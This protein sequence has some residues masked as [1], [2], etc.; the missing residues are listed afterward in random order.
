MPEP[1][2][3]VSGLR[4]IVGESLTEDVA[5][6]YALAFSSTLP[7][8]KFV[9]TN[10]ARTS[11]G[12][13]EQAIA[14]VLAQAGR[15]VFLGGPAATPTLGVLVR[16]EQAVGGIQISASHNPAQYN[17]MKLF[18]ADGRVLPAEAGATVLQRYHELAQQ[19]GK[20]AS[21]PVGKVARLD[22]PHA[23]H[24]QLIV[25]TV[26]AERIR[27]RKYRVLLDS[28]HGAGGPG[29]AR[30]LQE[31]G[32]Q[33]VEVGTTPD[34]AYEHPL[35]PTEENPQSVLQQARDSQCDVAFC[36]DPDADRLAV[37]DANGRYLGEELTLAMCVDHR[38]RQEVGPVVVNCSSSRVTEDIAQ[39]YGAPYF[40]SKV[41]EANVV[42]RMLAEDAVI[43]GEGNGGAID[44]RIV[45]VRDS[46]AG[47][48]LILEAMAS[49]ELSVAQLADELPQYA[50]V[51]SKVAMA[52]DAV[53]DSFAKLTGHFS[54]A[55]AD[56]LDGL[57]LDWPNR[58]LLIRASNTE[59]IVRMIA[60]AESRG[61][62]QSL[63]DQAAQVLE[64][65][66]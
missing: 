41:G 66:S 37:I 1:I 53:G 64:N 34:A 58:W 24:C 10:D 4:G 50:I 8:G 62:A 51:K 5:A 47:M 39:K 52:P 28:N 40:R 42:D 57:R 35:E 6:R 29:G 23:A 43:G 30:L 20:S 55:K 59:P 49:R 54:D 22:D 65:A 38:L 32:C 61:A 18:S 27:A 36:Q 15:D 13:L 12:M 26:D 46:L 19:A 16:A 7:P 3:T 48:A 56:R 2:I 11:A 45:L 44:P 25:D 33:V 9:I 17:G 31:L 63:C 60:E 14:R 21:T